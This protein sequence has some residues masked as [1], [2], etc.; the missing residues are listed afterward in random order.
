[1][2]LLRR[3]TRRLSPTE[4]GETLYRHARPIVDALQVADL[5]VR[6]TD[7]R[8]RGLLRISV[9]PSGRRGLSDLFLGYVE[10][11]PLV[12]LEVTATNRPVDLMAGEAD[13]A[14][15][16][17]TVMDPGLI[18]RILHSTALLLVAS[19][20]YLAS[21]GTPVTP[22]ELSGH[23]CLTGLFVRG[24][25]P[26]AQ[27]P[28]LD[29]GAVRITPRLSSN[30]MDLIVDAAV[31]GLGLTLLPRMRIEA[32]LRSGAL[33]P[34]LEEVVGARSTLAVVYPEREH[35]P[36]AVRTFVDHAVEWSQRTVFGT[37][38]RDRDRLPLA[39]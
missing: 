36:A 34:V 12:Q 20:A 10:A 13:V 37:R 35:L 21:A 6:R 8:P 3:T 1:M 24:E 16:A 28:L 32:E 11:H 39:T 7:G 22:A 2:R 38:T 15:R 5:A 33:V 4:A 26:M 30:E 14:L 9:P 29:G 25:Q 19:P 27:W 17:G 31:A 18:A 23:A